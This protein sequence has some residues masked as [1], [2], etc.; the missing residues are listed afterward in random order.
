MRPLLLANENTPLPSV[1]VLRDAGY[2]VRV[3]A[4]LHQRM[5]DEEVLSLAVN[6]KRWIVTFDRDYGE[7][8]YARDL[9]PPPALL[10]FRLRS[11]RPEDPGHILLDLLKDASRLAG[12]FVVV[13]DDRLRLRPLPMR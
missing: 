12:Q 6:D 9:A 3:I 13:E 11:Y 5:S 8:I 1:A 4:E 10:L 7:L 2:D